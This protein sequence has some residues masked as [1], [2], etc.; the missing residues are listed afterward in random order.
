MQI[1]FGQSVTLT[2][3]SRFF[4]SKDIPRDFY[5]SAVTAVA[6][7]AAAG[8]TFPDVTIL[9]PHSTC[10]SAVLLPSDEF[11]IIISVLQRPIRHL[12]HHT[13]VRRCA[14]VTSDRGYLQRSAFERFSIAG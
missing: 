2:R 6:A 13:H 9:V 5:L 4:P 10:L 11:N 1:I 14:T 3:M 7:A 8:S 12:W